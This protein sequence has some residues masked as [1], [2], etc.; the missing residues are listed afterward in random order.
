MWSIPVAPFSLVPRLGRRDLCGQNAA[1]VSVDT[2][3]YVDLFVSIICPSCGQVKSQPLLLTSLSANNVVTKRKSEQLVARL[4]K[5]IVARRKEMGLT[6]ERLA[7]LLG[8]DTETI[9]RFERG[10]AAPSLATLEALSLKLE[11]TI[12]ELLNEDA[13]EPIAEAQ[14]ITSLMRGLKTKEKGFLVDLVKLY[15]KQHG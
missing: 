4:G 12:A 14:M 5:N 1:S 2:T 3:Q 6:Q 10:A 15:C 8:V 11:V 7:E 13:P 9:S